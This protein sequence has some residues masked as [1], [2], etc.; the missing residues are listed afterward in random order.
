[1]KSM[2]RS[3][4][5]Y[6]AQATSVP[7]SAEFKKTVGMIRGILSVKSKQAFCDFIS[8]EG[9]HDIHDK[10]NAA[11]PELDERQSVILTATAES[12]LDTI[13][14]HHDDAYLAKQEEAARLSRK[15]ISPYAWG[16]LK[17]DLRSSLRE[18]ATNIALIHD[19]VSKGDEIHLPVTKQFK[20]TLN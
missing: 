12:I 19:S 10:L 9:L 13:R 1:M 18:A 6:N 4:T 5:G 20:M 8:G 3:S 14:L 17:S 7:E 15:Q 2:F 16:T 11:F